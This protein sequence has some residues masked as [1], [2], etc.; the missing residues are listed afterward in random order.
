MVLCSFYPGIFT[1][2]ASSKELHDLNNRN[3]KACEWVKILFYATAALF[4]STYSI[5]DW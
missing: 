5:V 1:R 2:H 4:E 3:F